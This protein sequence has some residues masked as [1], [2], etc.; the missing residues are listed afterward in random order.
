M[1]MPKKTQ[2]NGKLSWGFETALL[3]DRGCLKSRTKTKSFAFCRRKML[4]KRPKR[5]AFGYRFAFLTQIRDFLDSPFSLIHIETNRTDIVGK[6]LV[7]TK[8]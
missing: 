2:K 1:F 4:L 7:F 6:K 8:F 5:P 3:T